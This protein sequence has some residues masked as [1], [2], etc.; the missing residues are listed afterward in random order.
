MRAFSC[1]TSAALALILLDGPY[2]HRRWQ[3]YSPCR[4][5]F[6]WIATNLFVISYHRAGQCTIFRHIRTTDDLSET[7]TSRTI[8][9]QRVKQIRK[10]I[11]SVFL[12]MNWIWLQK[13]LRENDEKK[14]KKKNN[15]VVYHNEEWRDY[16]SVSLC[17]QHAIRIRL[18]AKPCTHTRHTY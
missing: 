5:E 18:Y 2:G 17:A 9:I 15:I 14:K 12:S 10:S 13:I 1:W 16:C 3:K 7:K 4:C 11:R 6:L 8:S